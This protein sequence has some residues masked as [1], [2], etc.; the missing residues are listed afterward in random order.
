MLSQYIRKFILVLSTVGVVFATSGTGLI[1]GASAHFNEE[2]LREF[3]VKA[4][5][6]AE[7]R[8]CMV[9]QGKCPFGCYLFIHKK[10]EDFLLRELSEFQ[11]ECKY[12]CANTRPGVLCRK[13]RCVGVVPEYLPKL[14][15]GSGARPLPYDQGQWRS[16][17]IWFESQKK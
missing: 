14:K 11:T 6:C 16:D 2:Q 5:E 10:H 4:G 9:V 8:D 1:P 12:A 7:H 15:K 17:S 13:K 3:I